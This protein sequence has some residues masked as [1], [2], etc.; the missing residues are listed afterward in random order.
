[1]GV[2]WPDQK[3]HPR[4]KVKRATK[5]LVD[6][7]RMTRRNDHCESSYRI[8]LGAGKEAAFIQSVTAYVLGP[9]EFRSV[10]GVQNNEN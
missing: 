1:M 9:F 2:P 4:E 5:G 3:N 7:S 10:E 6:N 8:L